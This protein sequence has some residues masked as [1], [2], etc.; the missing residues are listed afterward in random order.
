MSNGRERWLNCKFS[1]STLIKHGNPNYCCSNPVVVKRVESRTNDFSNDKILQ[2][3]P[4]GH[5]QEPRVKTNLDLW[6]GKCP[7]YKKVVDR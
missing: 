2:M 1:A 7:F 4:M 5:I 3:Y 6:C